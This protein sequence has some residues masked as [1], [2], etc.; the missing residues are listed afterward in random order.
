MFKISKIN[1]NLL[2]IRSAKSEPCFKNTVHITMRVGS[3]LSTKYKVQNWKS[4]QVLY[5]CTHEL[6]YIKH[7]TYSVCYSEVSGI[8]YSIYRPKNRLVFP[9]NTGYTSFITRCHNVTLHKRKVNKPAFPVS[10]YT[11]PLI[12]QNYVIDITEEK[13]N[14]FL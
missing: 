3:C 1:S 12:L 14:T 5:Q 4:V 9:S 10:L 6:V 11:R 13:N 8:S 2:N 7:K